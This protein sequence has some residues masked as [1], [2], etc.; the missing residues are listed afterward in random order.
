MKVF[1]ILCFLLAVLAVIAALFTVV[2][3]EHTL[4]EIESREKD[5]KLQI[6]NLREAIRVHA[7]DKDLHKTKR[8]ETGTKD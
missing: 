6:E 1:A 7:I 3:N 5:L 2:V 4:E 8:H